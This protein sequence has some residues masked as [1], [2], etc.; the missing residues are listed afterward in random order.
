MVDRLI[1]ISPQSYPVS[2]DP[3]AASLQNAV[4]LL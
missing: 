2:A 3:S 1:T 4:F